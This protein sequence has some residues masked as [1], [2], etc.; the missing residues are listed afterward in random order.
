M[1]EGGGC[2]LT[3]EFE[4]GRWLETG[5]DVNIETLTMMMNL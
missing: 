1:V 3:R 2:R 4:L 5:V